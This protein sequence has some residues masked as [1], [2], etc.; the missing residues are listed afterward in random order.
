M[1]TVNQVVK[2]N[3][4]EDSPYG[5]S[6]GDL[7]V[8]IPSLMPLINMGLPKITPVSLNKTCYCNANECKPAVSAKINTQN[9]ATADAPYGSYN[10]GCYYYGSEIA[11][12]SKTTDCLSCQLS[13]ANGDNSKKWPWED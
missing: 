8:Y 13:P 11:V 4:V 7:R 3:Y 1:F 6:S 10:R 12:I 5:T 9:Y 2:A